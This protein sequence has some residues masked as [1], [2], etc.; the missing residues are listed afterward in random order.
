MNTLVKLILL[1]NFRCGTSTQYYYKMTQTEYGTC[2]EEISEKNFCKLA[3][4][5]VKIDTQKVYTKVVFD[6]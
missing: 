2:F 5:P 1:I 3:E 6:E 4:Q